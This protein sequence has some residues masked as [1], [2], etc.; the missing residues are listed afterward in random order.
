[1]CKNQFGL[2][3]TPKVTPHDFISTKE[4]IYVPFDIHSLVNHNGAIAVYKNSLKT[5]AQSI[6]S[7]MKNIPFNRMIINWVIN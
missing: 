6:E 4:M 2:N 3:F 5:I 7:A 1:M